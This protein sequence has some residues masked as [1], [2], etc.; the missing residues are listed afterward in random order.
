MLIDFIEFSRDGRIVAERC[1]MQLG[2]ANEKR[3]VEYKIRMASEYIW[4][5]VC[6]NGIISPSVVTW[7]VIMLPLS[8]LPQH[9]SRIGPPSR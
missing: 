5:H 6:K 9:D 1:R 8:T 4:R 2:S 3:F 7:P